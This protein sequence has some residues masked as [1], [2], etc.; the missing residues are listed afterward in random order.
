MFL[1]VSV[2]LTEGHSAV[3]SLPVVMCC[4]FRLICFCGLV[5]NGCSNVELQ[6]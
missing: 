2:L 4:S 1:E 6:V 5:C 3:R